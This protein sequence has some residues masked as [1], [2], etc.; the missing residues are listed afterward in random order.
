MKSI[1]SLL[2]LATSASEITLKEALENAQETPLGSFLTVDVL[3]G[4]TLEDEPLGCNNGW[5]LLDDSLPM[6]TIEGNCAQAFLQ[7]SYTRKTNYTILAALNDM[8]SKNKAGYNGINLRVSS[9]TTKFP[10]YISNWPLKETK[11]VV[12]ASFPAYTELMALGSD[13]TSKVFDGIDFMM[14]E[15]TPTDTPAKSDSAK[16]AWVVESD[17]V[18]NKVHPLVAPNTLLVKHVHTIQGEAFSTNVCP[19]ERTLN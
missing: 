12:T 16:V 1:V 10:E 7:V 11:P 13:L 17:T 9:Y 15:L 14:V 3:S 4:P 6:E 8:E 5:C 18:A 19:S 2:I